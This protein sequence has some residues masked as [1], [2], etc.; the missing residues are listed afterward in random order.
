MFTQLEVKGL[1]EDSV[2]LATA[3]LWQGMEHMA[4]FSKFFPN[5]AKTLAWAQKSFGL[6]LKTA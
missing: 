1:L 4:R 5:F 6:C 2:V 3:D